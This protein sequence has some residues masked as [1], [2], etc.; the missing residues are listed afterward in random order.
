MFTRSCIRFDV[1]PY[2]T[3]VAVVTWCVTEEAMED[4]IFVVGGALDVNTECMRE[5]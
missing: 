2:G 1:G 4:S 3:Y 5:T